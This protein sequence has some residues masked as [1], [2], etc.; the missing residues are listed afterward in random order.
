[1]QITNSVVCDTSTGMLYKQIKPPLVGEHAFPL[2]GFNLH[3]LLT[4]DRITNYRIGNLHIY[5]NKKETSVFY[6][7]VSFDPVK[8]ST[9][10]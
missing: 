2:T 6:G 7:P 8:M 9:Q 4:F 10:K 1:M 5:S 3:I